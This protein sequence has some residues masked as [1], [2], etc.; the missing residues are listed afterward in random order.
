[1]ATLTPRL[2][3]RRKLG[4]IY[5]VVQELEATGSLDPTFNF[6]ICAIISSN[7]RLTFSLYF[8]LVSTNAHWNFSASSFPSL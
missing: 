6:S 5:I 8:E 4:S 1:M 2:I 3:Q 7:A